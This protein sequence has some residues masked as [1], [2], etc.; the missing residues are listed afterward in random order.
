MNALME[1]MIEIAASDLTTAEPDAEKPS[2]LVGT[3]SRG[4]TTRKSFNTVGGPP[5]RHWGRRSLPCMDRM[6]SVR[7][8]DRRGR[9]TQ[10]QE[11]Y[12]PPQSH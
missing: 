8:R 5:Q 12:E 9:D 4:Q 6:R 10:Q 7:V 11:L 3:N 2:L 1:R